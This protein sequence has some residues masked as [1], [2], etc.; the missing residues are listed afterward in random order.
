MHH[1]FADWVSTFLIGYHSISLFCF[2]AYFKNFQL[3]I[4]VH[5]VRWFHSD[6]MWVT[7]SHACLLSLSISLKKIRLAAISFYSVNH[8]DLKINRIFWMTKLSTS[9]WMRWKIKILKDCLRFH[10]LTGCC[11][12]S[13]RIRRSKTNQD[14]L[15]TFSNPSSGHSVSSFIN[16]VCHQMVFFSV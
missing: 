15:P 6:R 9:A 3:A 14:S 2:I 13:S 10:F 1:F 5:G 7:M 11:K 4:C 16:G 12:I 8:L